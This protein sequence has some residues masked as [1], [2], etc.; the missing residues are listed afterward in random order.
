MKTRWG[1]V[2][3]AV[4]GGIAAAIH[5]GKVPPAL[6]LLRQEL[7][8]D[9]VAAGWLMGLVS[10]IGALLGLVFG[11]IAD[12]LTHRRS[13]LLG[14]ALLAAGSFA[15][16][17]AGSVPL[18][19]ASRIIEGVGL[20]LAVVAGPALVTAAT[21]PADRGIAF[22][23][24]ATWL[25]LGVGLMMLA[26]PF[27]LAGFGWRGAWIAASAVT[28]VP[29]TALLLSPTRILA[30]AGGPSLLQGARLTAGQ[31]V[32]WL[33]AG[34]FLMYSA[35]FMSV[36][37]FLPTMLIEE[38]GMALGPASAMAAFAVLANVPGNIA[39]GMLLRRGAPRWALICLACIMLTLAA[40]VIFAAGPPLVLRYGAVLLYATAGGLLPAAI[41]GALPAYAARPDLVGTIS[42]FVMQG[43]NIGQFLGPL[44]L[45][46]IVSAH[47]W[48]ASP[49]YIASTSLCAIVL[50]L[51]FRRI[52]TR[53]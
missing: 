22:A 25:P 51:L 41:M 36:F 1:Q 17:F 24:W 11:R 19:F 30:A 26:S 34:M 23:A 45:A 5:V 38:N 28:L 27:I 15:G 4:L 35:S 16:A 10:L 31:P 9:L 53:L 12:R 20:I 29:L 40:F 8:L 43:T 3:I 49:Y 52:E 47:G 33:L 39:G 7:G 14:L 13:M 18:I 2:T 44:L 6:P 42:G 50:A 46:S 37:G 48:P 21:E 32:S